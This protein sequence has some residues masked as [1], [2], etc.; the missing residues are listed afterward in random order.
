M[1]SA[2]GNIHGYTVEARNNRIDPQMT[3]SGQIFDNRWTEVQFEKGP[4]GVPSP[5]P[6]SPL[7]L[8]GLFT[9]EQAQALR[10]WFVSQIHSDL[11]YR[12]WCFETRLASHNLEYSYSKTPSGFVESLDSGGKALVDETLEKETSTK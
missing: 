4:V 8:V 5:P 3:P 2:K 11:S 12:C 1:S 7:A 9:Y 10:W 6:D